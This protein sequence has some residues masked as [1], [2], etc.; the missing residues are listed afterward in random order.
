MC[1]CR[2]KKFNKHKDYGFWDQ[3]I[4]PSKLSRLGDP[5]ERLKKGVNFEMFR[6]LLEDKQ[7]TLPKGKGVRPPYNYVLMFKI[8]ISCYATV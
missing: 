1:L 3:D 8:M 6:D 4:R 7:I 2:M 5:L